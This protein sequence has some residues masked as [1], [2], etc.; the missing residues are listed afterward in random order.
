MNDTVNPAKPSSL[1]HKATIFNIIAFSLYQ[2]EIALRKYGNIT[3]IR[4]PYRDWDFTLGGTVTILR[5]DSMIQ[6][7]LCLLKLL[8]VRL[9]RDNL[10]GMNCSIKVHHQPPKSL[11]RK[12]AWNVILFV[13][14]GV[15]TCGT[16][17]V[18]RK[19]F[20]YSSYSPQPHI[21][22]TA[23]DVCPSLDMDCLV[24]PQCDTWINW[25]KSRVY[26]YANVRFVYSQIR[27]FISGHVFC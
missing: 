26:R 18:Y 11:S 4:K 6:R 17:L 8:F 9:N 12:L 19:S 5:L 23:I 24:I 21:I 27:T 2:K 10:R 7:P 16:L 1:D 25:Y 13:R 20:I 14:Q 3:P 15:R 22:V